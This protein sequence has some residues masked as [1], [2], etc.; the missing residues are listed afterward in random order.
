MKFN[1]IWLNILHRMKMNIFQ[2]LYNIIQILNVEL[3][4]NYPK[5]KM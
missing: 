2:K 4:Q 3:Y 1:K 5:Y